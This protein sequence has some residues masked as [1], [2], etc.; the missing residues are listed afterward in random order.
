M[1]SLSRSNS[2]GGVS[3]FIATGVNM[4]KRFFAFSLLL[5]TGLYLSSCSKKP[6]AEDFD[7]LIIGG[8]IVDGTG[9]P[10]YSS[11][12]AIKGDRI[13]RLGH[14][15]DVRAQKVIDATG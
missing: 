8:K 14:L 4:L 9:N 3:E 7:L 5:S 1:T 13:V 10:W 2:Q 6:T 15:S 12:L 11:D